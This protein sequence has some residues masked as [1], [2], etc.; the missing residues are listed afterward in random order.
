MDPETERKLRDLH[1]QDALERAASQGRADGPYACVE[2]GSGIRKPRF[3]KMSSGARYVSMT[4][5]SQA[6]HDAWASKVRLPGP[7]YPWTGEDGV[8][9][10][11]Y[12]P[13]RG[14]VL[15]E[16]EA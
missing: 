3:L 6:C 15:L 11:F 2:C 4:F 14:Y 9:K 16:R 1:D 8:L 12:I 7:H 5:C 13:K 10:G